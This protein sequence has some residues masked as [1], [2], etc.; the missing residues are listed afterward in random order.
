MLRAP[1]SRATS[2]LLEKHEASSAGSR[3]PRCRLGPTVCTTHRQGRSPASV[4]TAS[5]TARPSGWVVRRSRRHCSSSSGPAAAWI[6]PSTPPPP[7]S[8]ELAALTTT[9]TCCVVMSPRTASTRTIGSGPGE[10]LDDRG[11]PALA[12][13]GLLGGRQG[14]GVLALVAVAETGPGRG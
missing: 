12:R 13:L 7:S 8:E 3:W 5:P 10:L 11:H 9:S 1:R 14:L 2:R 4:A 6:A